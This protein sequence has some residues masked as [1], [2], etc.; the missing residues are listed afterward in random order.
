MKSA[1]LAAPAA[2]PVG[3]ST[4]PPGFG[5]TPVGVPAPA[6]DVVKL[7]TNELSRYLSRPYPEESFPLVPAASS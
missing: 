5:R 3:W 4:P 6:R 2:L 1:S 7:T